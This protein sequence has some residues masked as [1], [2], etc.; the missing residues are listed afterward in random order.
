MSA[1]QVRLM[2]CLY[3]LTT[4]RL[5]TAWDLFAVVKNMANNLD[6]SRLQSA[7]GPFK[8]DLSP[9]NLEL[10]KRAFWAIYTLD[11]YLCVMLGKSLTFDEIEIRTAHPTADDELINSDTTY[12]EY[13][14]GLSQ[15]T[16]LSLMLCPMAHAQLARTVRKTLKGLYLGL[17]N[18]SDQLVMEALSGEIR[19]W[20]F[21][22]PDFLKM[23]SAVG[24]RDIYARQ[25][26][27]IRLAQ[28]HAL[29][30]VYRPSLPLSGL[31][32]RTTSSV[33]VNGFLDD[34]SLRMCQDNCLQAALEAHHICSSLFKKGE[35]NDHYW[36]TAYILFCA[37][38]VMLVHIA[39]NPE[40]LQA[41]S[42]WAAAQDCCQMQ[43]QV[44]QSNRL[45]RRYVAALEDLS[46]QLKKRFPQQMERIRSASTTTL[47][48]PGGL[49]RT[50]STGNNHD[51]LSAHLPFLFPGDSVDL[52]LGAN[53]S[54]GSQWDHFLDPFL[55][56]EENATFYQFDS[57]V[58][59]GMDFGFY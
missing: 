49:D 55:S 44:C 59:G 11:T 42:A 29:I 14:T 15:T 27:V 58:S 34:N 45:A 56:N 1:L 22:L 53:T 31:A 7:V 26:T 20:E 21:M 40:G 33:T 4:S 30:M 57:L 12:Q 48:R 38:T 18:E 25:N 2:M 5:K 23:K 32:A 51:Q 16:G 35:V 19:D 43:R 47:A 52:D 46:K 50:M 28:Q 10:R 13:S 36:F 54:P 6:L 24:L 37:A 3:L 39:H 9:L 17:G 41:P 8:N